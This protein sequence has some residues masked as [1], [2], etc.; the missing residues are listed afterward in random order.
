MRSSTSA[1]RVAAAALLQP[2]VPGRVDVGA[3]RHFFSAQSR[4]PPAAA[5]EAERRGI[6]LRAPVLQINS[7]VGCTLFLAWQDSGFRRSAAHDLKA[8]FDKIIAGRKSGPSPLSRH[9]ITAPNDFLAASENA[10]NSVRKTV[11][12]GHLRPRSAGYV[13]ETGSDRRRGKAFLRDRTCL[14]SVGRGRTYRRCLSPTSHAEFGPLC[15]DR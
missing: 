12:A 9:C 2:S 11:T 6:E 1:G 10:M 5:G 15:D 8:H 4:R 13:A 7:Q 14:P 3:L